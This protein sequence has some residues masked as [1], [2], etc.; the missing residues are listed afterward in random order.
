MT[1]EGQ[2]KSGKN[3][4]KSTSVFYSFR[5]TENVIHYEMD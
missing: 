1:N 4:R 3:I 2:S 5:N